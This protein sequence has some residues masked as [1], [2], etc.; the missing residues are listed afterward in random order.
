MENG[1]VAIV[2]VL[3]GLS[4]AHPVVVTVEHSVVLANEYISQDP[5]RPGGGGDVQAHEATQAESLTSLALL[6]WG[7]E[8]RDAQSGAEQKG[9]GIQRRTQSHIMSTQSHT[10]QF[11]TE[12]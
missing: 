5:K 1:D 7:K 2:V 4:E 10:K 11:E 12:G 3:L 8:Y 6:E 9:E